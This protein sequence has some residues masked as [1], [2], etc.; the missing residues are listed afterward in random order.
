MSH[1]TRRKKEWGTWKSQVYTSSTLQHVILPVDLILL[2]YLVVR[3]CQPT[4]R[5]RTGCSCLL[6]THKSP[7]DPNPPWICFSNLRQCLHP[8]LID[9]SHLPKDDGTWKREGR[10]CN[11]WFCCLKVPQHPSLHTEIQVQNLPHVLLFLSDQRLFISLS[12]EHFT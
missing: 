5:K 3:C 6:A 4:G 9:I 10:I 11:T 2:I 1:N 8:S 7:A 12:K